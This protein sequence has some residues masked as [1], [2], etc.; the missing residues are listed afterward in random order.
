[1]F[2]P[3]TIIFST[4]TLDGR[5]SSSLGSSRLSCGDD[6]RLQHLLRSYSD[7]VMV[8]AN[9]ILNDNPRLTTRLVYGKNPFRIV[10]DSKLKVNP[11]ARVFEN[12]TKSILVTSASISEERLIGFRKKGINVLKVKEKEGLDVLEMME[13]LFNIGVKKL[14]VEGGGHLNF[15]L[16]RSGVVDEIWVTISPYVFGSGV[17]IF[18]KG[19]YGEI[20]AQLYVK[21]VNRLCSDWIN[22]KYGVLYPKIPLV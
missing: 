22:I 3:Y 8:G 18:E 9:T 1:M 20:N 13:R 4:Q 5:I 7:G 19:I 11:G 2:R 14:M 17:A 16:L 10:V 6:F 12:P 15:S 21:S